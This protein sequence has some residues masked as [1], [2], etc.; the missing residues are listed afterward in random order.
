MSYSYKDSHI[1][2]SSRLEK[3][4]FT[5]HLFLFPVGLMYLSWLTIPEEH[6][7]TI[8]V[9]NY[10][11]NKVYALH[12]PIT[13]IFIF[14]ATPLLYAAFNSFIV[15]KINSPDTVEDIYTKSFSTPRRTSKN[16]P[17]F[18][19]VSVLLLFNPCVLL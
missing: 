10:Y 15:P 9:V 5:F 14:M 16:R 8:M 19:S 3:C 6:V 17:P 12:V 11:P 2:T 7:E 4:S 13:A 1:H 18:E